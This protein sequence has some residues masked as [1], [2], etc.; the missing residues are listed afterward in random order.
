[1]KIEVVAPVRRVEW[2]V[3]TTIFLFAA[4]MAGAAAF[5][6]G[7][8]VWESLSRLQ[9]PLVASV[10]GLSLVNY[11][12]R[13]LRW[14][15]YSRHL[16]MRVRLGRS[17]L[18]YVAG[19]ALTTTPGKV[20]EV[21]RLWL[22]ERC[23]GEPYERT[24]PLLV[25]DRLTDLGAMALLLLAGLTVVSGQSWMVAVGVAVLGLLGLFAARPGLA[26][27]AVTLGFRMVGRWPRL[28]GKARRAARLTGDLFSPGMLAGAM[29]LAT[30]GWLAECVGFYLVLQALG[31]DVSVLTATFI[32]TAAM[33]VGGATLVPG[34]LGGTEATMLGLLAV[35]GVGMEIAV[36][37][38]MVCRVAT[39]WF[40]VGLGLAVMPAA[41]RVA[42][43]S[44]LGADL[45]MG[46]E[47]GG[48]VPVGGY[49]PDRVGHGLEGLAPREAG[50][51]HQPHG[52]PWHALQ[53]AQLDAPSTQG[54]GG[55]ARHQRRPIAGGH[56]VQ[57]RL[58][59]RRAEGA[60][61]GVR[62]AA[63]S[64]GLVA[65]AVPIRQHQQVGRQVGLRH[66]APT[67][68]GVSLRQGGEE[69]LGE[70]RDVHQPLRRFG[71]D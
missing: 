59:P 18:Y 53:R 23:E 7:D 20:G 41:L 19:F 67:R 32:F 57:Q 54:A 10:F 62:P 29:V 22:M 27:L 25:A 52:A 13:A 4:L 30:L 5:A 50:A 66:P 2:A 37:A 70:E 42:K 44:G 35:A 58:E 26:A 39:L 33:L 45:D 43:A 38:T 11:A 24:L 40:A 12:L 56:H 71:S 63:G 69:R 6:G 28:F 15:F 49:A 61:P 16:G 65:Q 47:G 8:K 14:H 1:M 36:P 48:A 55:E 34:G 17:A 68:Q 9:W 51:A 64:Q 60:G 21:L 3:A 46:G 31:A